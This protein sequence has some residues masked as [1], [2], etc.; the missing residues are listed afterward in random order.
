MY[1]TCPDGQLV[2]TPPAKA[3][4]GLLGYVLRLSE[5]NGY[6]TPWHILKMAGLTQEQMTSASLSI[7]KLSRLIGRPAQE[8]EQLP[9]QRYPSGDPVPKKGRAEL[10]A[11][12]LLKQ[13]KIC[14]HCV[15]ENGNI[16]PAW[17]LRVMLACPKHGIALVNRCPV[18]QRKLSWFRPGLLRCRC[19]HD[20][21]TTEN[22]PISQHTLDLLQVIYDT[23]HGLPT[24]PRPPSRIPASDL[25]RMGID[26][27]L[28]LLVK[29]GNALIGNEPQGKYKAWSQDRL[30]RTAA[31]FQDWPSHF[32]EFL[33]AHD[34]KSTRAIVGLTR[35]F[36][37]FYRSVVVAKSIPR[38]K[39]SFLRRAFGEYGNHNGLTAGA[40][41]R[42]F[43]SPQKWQELLKDFS[44]SQ[45]RRKALNKTAP[46]EF[47]NQTELARSI[48][49]QRTTA[50]HWAERGLFGLRRQTTSL[51]GQTFYELP[52]SLPS[53]ATDMLDTREA[54]RCLEMPVSILKRLR[55]DGYY[56]TE[57]FGTR[58]SQ[59]NQLDL[60]KLRLNLLERAPATLLT[61]PTAHVMLS[62]IFRMRLN[63]AENK[64]QIVRNIMEG[65]LIPAGRLGERIGEIVIANQ[66]IEAFREDISI[67]KTIPAS[68]AAKILECD[69]S[70]CSALVTSGE[71]AGVY[72]G[73]WLFITTESIANFQN[74]YVSCVSIAK[75]LRTSS[76]HI[77]RLLFA[78]GV[79]LLSVQ[80]TYRS[81]A[82]PQTFCPRCY[83][84]DNFDLRC[85]TK[86]CSV[87]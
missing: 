68:R 55:R 81:T 29:V 2:Y 63:G 52:S 54:A 14:P 6:D 25:R 23:A 28:K 5:A 44:V 11:N 41:P 39:M 53:R 37:G 24:N 4:E 74:R 84:D 7:D 13:P 12:L 16:D 59:F 32:H 61:L 48:G 85:A 43:L 27:L 64:Y 67:Q 33:H 22:Q 45:I 87:G 8:L 70:V 36:E 42:F 60:N 75:R 79:E 40:D 18:C 65:T 77:T 78:G 86:P 51:S 66:S 20:I 76:Q 73:R 15:A 50:R 69:A 9:W 35:R 56:C 38:E 31:F 30:E 58:A 47:V 71:L 34:P 49:V 57:Y 26:D 72:H 10:L 19:G 62:A 21:V 17:D 3:R 82:I 80:R 83:A 46:V 1:T